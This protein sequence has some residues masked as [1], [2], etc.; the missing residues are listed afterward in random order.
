M[1][2]ENDQKN[3]TPLRILRAE[4][5][6][7]DIQLFE[8]ARA[9]GGLLP[10]FTPGAHIRVRTPNGLIRRY[11]LCNP[12]EEADHYVLAVKRD[13]NGQGGSVSLVD[14]AKVG[15]MLMV[16]EP[17]NAFALVGNPSS[18][19]FI[20][21]GIGVTPFLSMGKHLLATGGKPF[22]LYYLTRSAES[23]AFLDELS[24]PPFKG[25][26]IIHHDQ[27]DLSRAFDLWP[28]FEQQK[29]AQVY[30][31]GPR[32][33]MESVRDMTGHWSSGSVRFEDFGASTAAHA[34]ENRPFTVRLA[35]TGAAFEVSPTQ[36][37]LEALVAHGISVRSSCESGSCGTCKVRVLEGEPE[38]RDLALTEQERHNTIMACV[39]RAASDELVL[40]L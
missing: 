18:Y 34:K 35:R 24:K 2:N 39:S 28:V 1:E 21:G 15:D 38:H 6:A 17:E 32:K 25:R 37:L 23:T 11:S 40:D 9:D 3:M 26:V 5:A 30:C 22:K 12:P 8:L 31:C 36:T 13:A 7:A 20:A 14:D 10:A 19:I 4:P 33:L 16:G 29:G 27:G